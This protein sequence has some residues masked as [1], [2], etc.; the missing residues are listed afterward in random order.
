MRAMSL[1]FWEKKCMGSF[2][3]NKAHFFNLLK[4]VS[5]EQD[6]TLLILNTFKGQGGDL[7]E[8]ILKHHKY[9]NFKTHWCLAKAFKI[10]TEEEDVS[11]RHWQTDSSGSQRVAVALGEVGSSGDKDPCPTIRLDPP[12][13]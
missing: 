11:R 6:L 9:F 10:E 7:S 8:M 3:F 4:T 2:L 12:F 1:T 5:D 13:F